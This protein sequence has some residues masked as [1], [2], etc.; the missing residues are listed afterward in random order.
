MSESLIF[1][2]VVAFTVY[3]FMRRMRIMKE[4]RRRRAEIPSDDAVQDDAATMPRLG[5]PG[6]IT[7][8]QIRFLKQ[9]NFEPS[10]M[11]SRE[12]A[13]LVLDALIYLRTIIHDVTGETDAP[14]EIQNHLLRFILTEEELRDYV[15]EW[16]LNRTREEEENAVLERNEYY[17]QV[18]T[19]VRELWED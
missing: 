9:N 8:E 19:T 10:R 3:L 18:E 13:Q 15:R 4:Q 11:W 7:R 17:T 2:L 5:Q 6:T 1:A 12:E 14:I 16:G